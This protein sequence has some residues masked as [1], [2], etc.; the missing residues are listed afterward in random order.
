[1]ASKTN[2]F[3]F[4]QQVRAETAK[5]TWPSRRETMISTLMVF[6][7]VFF[8]AVFFFAADQLLGWLI[9]LVLNVGI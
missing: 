8:A 5:V 1:M 3:T 4:L 7:M 6:V 2:P 9:G